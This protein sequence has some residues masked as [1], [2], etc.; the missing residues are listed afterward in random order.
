MNEVNEWP[1]MPREPARWFSRFNRFRLAGPRRSLLATYNAERDTARK[2]ATIP[3]AWHEAAE[4]WCWRQ[5]AE[6]WDAA[7]LAAEDAAW[8]ERRREQRESDWA[9]SRAL[10]GL[11]AQA[12]QVFN[13]TT[14]SAGDIARLAETASKIARLSCELVTDHQRLD[15]NPIDW[16]QVP[17]D[18][19]EAFADSKIGLDDVL[20][21]LRRRGGA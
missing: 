6:G 15:I 19:L 3:G 9:V 12:L 16:S 18:I 10:L 14:A 13:P 21:Y 17:Q 1:R 5:R 2:G 20:R 4:R 11:A 8:T 7:Q